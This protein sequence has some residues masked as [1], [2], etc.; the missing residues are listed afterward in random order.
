MQNQ[1]T[2][3]P[4]PESLLWIP[5]STV[6]VILRHYDYPHPQEPG[7]VIEGYDKAHAL[8][9][10]KMSA[11]VAHHLGHDSDRVRLYQ[12]ACL[13]HDLGRAG[14]DQKLSGEIWTWAKSQGIPTRPAEWRARYPETVYGKEC[15][16][17]GFVTNLSLP[18]LSS[19][20]T[21]NDALCKAV[22]R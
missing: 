22:A 14:L 8:R 9:T 2:L 3:G 13:L 1:S 6:A 18:P 19:S 15:N 10:A 5:G 7:K 20:Q 12:I 4:L 16:L 21:A 17:I 11:A